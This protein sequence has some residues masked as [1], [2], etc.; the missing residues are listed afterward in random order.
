M[1]PS[2]EQMMQA[3][4]SAAASD[5][6]SDAMVRQLNT[7]PSDAAPDIVSATQIILKGSQQ[8]IRKLCKE[9]YMKGDAQHH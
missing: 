4:S 1:I 6:A 3:S 5:A 9:F 7:L 2:P 8:D